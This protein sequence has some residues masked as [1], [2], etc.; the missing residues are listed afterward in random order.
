MKDEKSLF[1]RIIEGEIPSFKIFENEYVYSFLDINPASYGH[2]LV[3]PKEPA[4]SLH[5]LSQQSASELGKA[6]AKISKSILEVTGVTSYNIIQNNGSEAGQ[7]VFHVHFHIIPKYS[8]SNHELTWPTG[9]L[10][11]KDASELA[12]RISRG[13]I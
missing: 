8:D 4:S 13:I 7:T 3:V 9:S 10:D 6:L 12:D 1:T 2:T 5:E 11:N